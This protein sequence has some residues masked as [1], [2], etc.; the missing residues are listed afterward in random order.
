MAIEENTVW[1]HVVARHNIG[2][3]CG[4]LYIE[5]VHEQ[6]FFFLLRWRLVFA[7]EARIMKGMHKLSSHL[8]RTYTRVV[9]VT[10][11]LL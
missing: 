8:G 11:R 5:I 7:L 2:R 10:R 4:I 3:F 6:R 9:E 1:T